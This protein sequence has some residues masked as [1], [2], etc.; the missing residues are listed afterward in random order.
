MLEK[1]VEAVAYVRLDHILFYNRAIF[2]HSLELEL[3]KVD[4]FILSC[5]NELTKPTPNSRRLHQPVTAEAVRY[6]K[7]ADSWVSS[8]QSVMVE[9]VNAEI[10]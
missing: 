9:S 3:T 4:S 5:D 6:E 7:I 1:V 2:F 8:N 10:K